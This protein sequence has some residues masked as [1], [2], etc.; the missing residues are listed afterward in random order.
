MSKEA[1]T[2]ASAGGFSLTSILTIIFVL[3]KL[4]GIIG[5]SWWLVFAPTLISV[6]FGLL[7]LGGIVLFLI[8][9]FI[10]AILEG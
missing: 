3:A 6:A 8:V 4:A 10:F 2:T 9:A 7:I 1:V 5:W